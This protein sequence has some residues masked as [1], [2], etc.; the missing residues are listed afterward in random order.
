MSHR[1]LDCNFHSLN[2]IFSE[3][4]VFL[5]D[6]VTPVYFVDVQGFHRLFERTASKFSGQVKVQVLKHGIRLFKTN[7]VSHVSDQIVQDY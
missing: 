7:I 2:S 5:A 3:S 6:W 1:F 4:V